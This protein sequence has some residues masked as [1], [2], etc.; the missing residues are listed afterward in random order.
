VHLGIDLAGSSKVFE[1]KQA[2]FCRPGCDP[3]LN[4]RLG[5]LETPA[6]AA[7]G[8]AGDASPALHRESGFL[9]RIVYCIPSDLA[10]LSSKDYT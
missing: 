9:H 4:G 8:L 10:Y 2:T 7:N 5:D 6:P 3:A 1:G